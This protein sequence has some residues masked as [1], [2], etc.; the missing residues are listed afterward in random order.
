LTAG[1]TITLKGVF[2]YANGTNDYASPS[3]VITRTCP[4]P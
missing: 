4:L 2:T 3:A 1:T